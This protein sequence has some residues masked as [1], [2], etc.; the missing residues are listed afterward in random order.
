MRLTFSHIALTKIGLKQPSLHTVFI[1]DSS[2][3]TVSNPRRVFG[4]SNEKLSFFLSL[5]F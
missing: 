4:L 1:V 2:K 5:S 3:N